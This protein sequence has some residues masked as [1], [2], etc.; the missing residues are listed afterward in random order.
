[1]LIKSV[2]TY[3]G[4][5]VC[6]EIEGHANVYVNE[7]IAAEYHLKTGSNIPESALDEIIEADTFRKA[8]ER[9]LHLLTDRDHCFVELYNKLEKNY[10]HEI[11]LS[12]CRK[13]AEMGFVNDALYAEKFA[14]QLFEVKKFGMYR[15]KQEM[16]RKGLPENV[17]EN[18][19]EPYMDRDETLKRLEELV[20]KKYAR[21][22]DD[23]K[24]VKKVKS[25]L[26][27]LGYSYDDINT[28]LKAYGEEEYE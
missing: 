2:G 4:S 24:G 8:K 28:V 12:V 6:I 26:V 7:K 11:C 10:P 1:M 16:K 14:R 17:I 25:A 15:A 22:L 3:K 21:Y 9:A 27:R 23:D 13:M 18:A 20:D 5:T 19:I